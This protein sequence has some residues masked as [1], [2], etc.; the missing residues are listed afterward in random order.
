MVNEN[1]TSTF[2]EPNNAPAQPELLVSAV[3]HLMSHYTANNSQETQSCVKLASVIERHLKALAELPNLAPVLRAT[4][5]QL[6]EQWAH[7]VE[8][9]MPPPEKFNFFSRMVAGARSV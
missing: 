8:R 6:S 2:V 9:T 3:L 1:M 7:V 4:C 5:Q